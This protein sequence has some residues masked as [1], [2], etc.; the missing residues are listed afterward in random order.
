MLATPLST[1]NST[2]Y[3]S[4]L[5]STHNFPPHIHYTGD[6]S[7]NK[8]HHHSLSIPSYPPKSISSAV[9]PYP[10]YISSFLNLH[11]DRY[12]R[13]L[14]ILTSLHHYCLPFPMT[15]SSSALN[16]LQTLCSFVFV[17][18]VLASLLTH[19]MWIRTF[20]LIR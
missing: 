14:N 2:H 8:Q 11:D 18:F 6:T 1:M 5:N 7:I 20:M 4:T 9:L 16:L 13:S 3:F 15:I 17:L 10:F 12:E 19:F